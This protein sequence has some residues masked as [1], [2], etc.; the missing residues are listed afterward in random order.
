MTIFTAVHEP[1][2]Y[3]G[4][5]TGDPRPLLA[6]QSF[7]ALSGRRSSGRRAD[8]RAF[9]VGDQGAMLQYA[10]AWPYRCEP[11]DPVPRRR[12]GGS[13]RS[14]SRGPAGRRG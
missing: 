8:G 13:C 14:T 6:G 11:A 2:A 5:A 4:R 10:I 3:P 12:G 1:R 7:G 9:A